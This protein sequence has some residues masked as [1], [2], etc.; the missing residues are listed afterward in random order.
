MVI[1]NE[2]VH[3]QRFSTLLQHSECFIQKY[4]YTEGMHNNGYMGPL[5]SDNDMNVKTPMEDSCGGKGSNS[6]EF[7][8]G[9]S[10]WKLYW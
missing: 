6:S 3:I 8:P 10:E 1:V 9:E 7:K 5:N 2:P 4:F